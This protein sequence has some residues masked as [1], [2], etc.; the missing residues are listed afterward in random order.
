MKKKNKLILGATG[1]AMSLVAFVAG[2]YGLNAKIASADSVNVG[3]ARTES[4]RVI[5]SGGAV[6]EPFI[7]SVDTQLLSYIEYRTPDSEYWTKYNKGSLID[8][9]EGWYS[10]QLKGFNEGEEPY[11]VYYDVT[12]PLGCVFDAVSAKGSGS[13][14]SNQYVKYTAT[15][16]GSGI[17]KM[18]VQKPDSDEFVEYADGTRFTDDG[19]YLFK[20]YDLAGNVTQTIHEITLDIVPDEVEILE[21][22][23]YVDGAA[24]ESGTFTNGESINFVCNGDCY[25]K[26]PGKSAFTDYVSGTEFTAEGRYEF[27]AENEDEATETHVIVIDREAETLMINKVSAGKTW[28]DVTISWLKWNPN[29][30]AQVVRIT[31]NGY[32]YEFDSTVCTLEGKEYEVIGY[33]QAGNE[34]RTTINAGT[35]DVPTITLQKEYWEVVH[36][37]TGEIQSY[38]TYEE[39]VS[40]AVSMERALCEYRTW[41]TEAWDQG[42]AMDTKDSV[43]A[44]NGAYYLYKSESDPEK[45]VAYFTQDRLN[46]VA[47]KYAEE[48]VEHYYYWEKAA[49][50]EITHKFHAYQNE[51]KIVGREVT[52]REGLHYTLDG[53]AYSGLTIN[54]PGNHTL[55][56]EDGYGNSVEYEICIL[57]SAPTIQ[58][59]LGNNTAVNAGYGRTYYFSGRI[60]L[61]I[62]NE[63]DDLAVFTVYK[64]GEQLGCYD[65]LSACYIEESGEY[66]VE[67][68]NHYGKS[69]TFAFVVSMSLPTISVVENTEEERL[70]ISIAESLD[71]DVGI[72]F[73]EIARSLDGGVTWE[74][75]SEDSYGRAI[76]VDTLEYAFTESGLYKITVMDDFRTGIDAVK[77]TVEFNLL[78]PEEVVEEVPDLEDDDITSVY[79]YIKDTAVEES[80]NVVGIIAAVFGGAI[81]LSVI[82]VL[83]LKHRG[84][85]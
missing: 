47:R 11:R 40:S 25:V 9:A 49:E 85:I 60:T 8:G 19:T 62:P 69:R 3:V 75:L 64:N 73:L 13:T 61:S 39:A 24:V 72:E 54:A 36:F 26:L 4:G 41:T 31:I 14:T 78:V 59:A 38:S 58:Y 84:V 52:L 27:Y 82:V 33:D 46:E 70:E 53:V 12:A 32:D 10:F 48:R 81:A 20:A 22:Q 29:A 63:G 7:Y 35:V 74:F 17:D 71:E 28:N 65:I 18:Y 51:N 6:N 1:L 80:V 50:G 77:E 23:L 21:P 42:V 56:I 16:S 57:D 67:A 5:E 45:Q 30:N 76:T 37:W 55:L 79:E 66:T 68:Y 83:I 44:K 2:M 15:D 34:Y 43:N